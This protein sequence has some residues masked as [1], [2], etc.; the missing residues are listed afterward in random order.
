MTNNEIDRYNRNSVVIEFRDANKEPISIIPKLDAAF[1]EAATINKEV[2]LNKKIVDTG[3]SGMV[4]SKDISRDNL[5]KR[6]LVFAGAL[7]GC[8][9]DKADNELMT[10][11]DLNSRSFTK[12]RDS[13]VP[14]L[15]ESILDKCD[16]AGDA[17][18]PFGITAEKRTGFRTL[19]NEHMDKF[20]ALNQGKIT[21]K[22]ANATIK[23]LLNKFDAKLVVIKKLMLGFEESN[24]EM[25]AK[26]LSA[27]E[28]VKSAA[29]KNGS[30]TT[31]PVEPA[32]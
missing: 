29:T 17:L 12:L 5:I 30:S 11:S 27:C 13:Q 22:T 8:A 31:A 15:I 14:L 3:T 6:G 20:A 18:I 16:A 4:I 1:N 10:F 26:F 7:Y 9:V 19:L 2:G 32:K 23:M 24:Q 21:K 28:I 25:Y